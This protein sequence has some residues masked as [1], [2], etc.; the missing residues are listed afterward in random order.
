MAEAFRLE[1]AEI[2]GLI[3]FCR[4]HE[5]K[6]D[7]EILR[8]EQDVL[9]KLVEMH[10]LSPDGQVIQ[11]AVLDRLRLFNEQFGLP[12]PNFKRLGASTTSFTKGR[13]A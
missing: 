2:R 8:L 11:D 3:K 7:A 10:P 5:S 6:Y 4:S 12:R 9:A 13:V 1:L